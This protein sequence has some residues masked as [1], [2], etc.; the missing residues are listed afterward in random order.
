[1]YM[2]VRMI[3]CPF[4]QSGQMGE[5]HLQGQSRC[6]RLGASLMSQLQERA[7][8]FYWRK[9]TCGGCMASEESMACIQL[10]M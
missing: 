3:F 10:S 2:H 1:M 8:G 7:Q 9:R 4:D 6:L 5:S